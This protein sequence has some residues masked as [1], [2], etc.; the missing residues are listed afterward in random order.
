MSLS[1]VSVHVHV[2]PDIKQKQKRNEKT[3]KKNAKLEY[4][5]IAPCTLRYFHHMLNYGAS[6]MDNEHTIRISFV[7]G[8]RTATYIILFPPY[9]F[10]AAAAATAVAASL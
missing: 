4:Y 2:W 3:K 1:L 10:S 8:H 5:A 6:L 9:F 7:C